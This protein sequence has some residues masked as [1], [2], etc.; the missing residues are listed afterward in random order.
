MITKET[1]IDQITVTENG[2]ILVR[3]VTRYLDEG[4]EV[5]STFHRSSYSPSTDTSNLP[6]KVKVI[7]DVVWTQSV[8]D[9]YNQTSNNNV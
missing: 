7:A 5:T 1:K 8:I 9:S 4:V 6:A 3:E 2:I